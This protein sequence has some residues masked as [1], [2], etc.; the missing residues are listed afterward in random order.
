MMNMLFIQYGIDHIDYDS[1]DDLS[2]EESEERIWRDESDWL[3][4]SS[5]Y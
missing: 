5:R 1:Y 2:N 4:L 3:G